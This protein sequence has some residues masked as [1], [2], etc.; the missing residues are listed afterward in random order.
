[1]VKRVTTLCAILLVSTPLVASAFSLDDLRAQIAAFTS[2]FN[3]FSSSYQTSSFTPPAQTYTF[4]GFSDYPQQSTSQSGLSRSGS[5]V[6]TSVTTVWSGWG[7]G[8]RA[9][10]EEYAPVCGQKQVMCFA[11]PCNPIQQTYSNRCF[12]GLDG[13]TYVHDGVCSTSTPTPKPPTYPTTDPSSDP[14]CKSWYDGCNTCARQYPGGPG[15]CTLRACIR[16]GEAYCSSYFSGTETN[17][18]P[19][20]T[21]FSGPT[22]LSVNQGGTWTIQASDP[23]GGYLSYDISWGDEYSYPY[24]YDASAPQSFTQSSTFTHAYAS[25]GTYTV[26]V[27]V[28]DSSGNTAQTSATVQVRSGSGG[29]ACTLEYD[30]VCGQ[31]PVPRCPQGAMCPMYYPAPT[32][33]GNMCLMQ[34]AG[35]TL[36]YRGTCESNFWRPD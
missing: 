3:P 21:A 10:T 26:S 2:Q 17:R 15:M 34:K 9:C 33:Y 28:T 24:A 8:G 36:L 1:M 23:E 13:A 20:I 11:A 35:A 19:V 6:N 4:P 31:P 32:T 12:M 14:M 25:A 29:T 16:Q 27:T 30:P 7:G 22:T 18:D 5:G